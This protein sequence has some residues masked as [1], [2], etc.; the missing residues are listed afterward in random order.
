M[1]AADDVVAPSWT[2]DRW[3]ALELGNGLSAPAGWASLSLEASPFRHLSLVAG[4]GYADQSPQLSLMSRVWLPKG[5]TSV[6]AIVHALGVGWSF[7][8]RTLALPAPCESNFPGDDGCGPGQDQ[9]P[10]DKVWETARRVNIEY[11]I[12]L[13]LVASALLLRCSGGLSFLTNANSYACAYN[14]GRITNCE[15]QSSSDGNVFPYLGVGLVM[16]L[17]G[18]HRLGPRQPMSE[19]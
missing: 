8:R 3:L 9:S 13:P 5:R 17:D 16:L 15:G 4:I 18:F 12:E 2:G 6:G 11:A 14:D 10:G 19:Q 1:A 7:G